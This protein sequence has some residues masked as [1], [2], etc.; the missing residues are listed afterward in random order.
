MESLPSLTRFLALLLASAFIG[1]TG[2][3]DIAFDTLQCDES[4]PAYASPEDVIMTCEEGNT[5]CSFGKEV[6][7]RGTLQYHS[8]GNYAFNGTGYASANLR[9]VSVEYNLVDEYPINFCG[10]WVEA[11]N[12]SY[13]DNVAC[14]DLDGYYY[15]NIPYKLP[16]DDDDLT[17]WVA[18]GWSGV[19]SLTV[20]TGPSDDS[21]LLADCTLHWHTY[22]TPSQ[23]E[24]WK[25]MPSAA[26]SSIVVASVL[27]AI[28]CAC[29]WVACCKK[30]E[31]H[32][33]DIGYYDDMGEYNAIHDDKTLLK[34]NQRSDGEIEK[35]VEA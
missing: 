27:T 15:F 32:V 12:H 9:L 17:T 30:R 34:G 20:H 1:S 26:Q 2:A 21:D 8:L 13:G 7:I 11:Y 31:K 10:D 3:I 25:T 16:F 4:L 22:V 29:T 18:T 33:T 23:A 5:R 28:L 24:G 14:P 6:S 35:V 19:S